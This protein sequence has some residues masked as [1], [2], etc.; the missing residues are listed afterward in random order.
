MDRRPMI[1]V[2]G[3]VLAVMLVASL[4][5]WLQLPAD[6]RVP[7]HWGPDGQPDGWADK[8]VGLFL[9]PAIAGLVAILLAAIPRF[10][11]RRTNLARSA[12]AYGATWVGLMVFLGGMHLLAIGV[13]LGAEIDLTR[14]VMVGV[15]ALF[16]VI[17]NYLPKVRP[18]YM[19]GVRT[20][21]T[22]ASDVSWRRTHRLAGRLFVVEGVLIAGLGLVG[23]GGGILVAVLL[24][25]IAVVLIVSFA[26]SY[27]AWKTDP[28]RRAS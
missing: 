2:S 24:T 13:A 28:E 20:P 19:M 26:Y 15:G 16:I 9:M 27:Q 6:A 4:W 7:I 1:A 12:K 21:W 23:A 17:G 11:P 22:L 18:N 3:I 8:T 25:S 10:E 14:I 5:A